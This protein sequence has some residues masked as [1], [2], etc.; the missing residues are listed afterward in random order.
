MVVLVTCKN[1]EGPI[2]NEGALEWSQHYSLI[3]QMFKG[4][5]PKSVIESC[6]YSNTSKLLW[7]KNEEHPSENEGN[8]VVTTFL[9][10]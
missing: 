6:L 1:E 3:F 8:N 2:K 4:S 9:P 5:Y 10:L 7:F